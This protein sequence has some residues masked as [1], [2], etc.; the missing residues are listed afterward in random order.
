M[1]GASNVKAAL[2][3]VRDLMPPLAE[4]TR[5]TADA[6]TQKSLYRRLPKEFRHD[7][8][9]FRQIAREGNAAVYEQTWNGCAEPSLAFEVIRVR[10]RE[11]FQIGGRF[12]EP[13][14]VYPNSEAWG[15]DGFAFTNRDA[16]FTKLRGLT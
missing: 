7:G 5:A 12:V 15:I 11:G 3:F 4:K 16:A 6:R 10:R 1:N 14:E 9:T 8:F 2:P 13:A